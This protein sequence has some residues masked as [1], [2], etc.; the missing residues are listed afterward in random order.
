[1]R[2]RNFIFLLAFISSP[3]FGQEKYPGEIAPRPSVSLGRLALIYLSVD[4]TPEQR[5]KLND[6]Y[7]EFIFLVDSIGKATLEDVNGI[8]D[9]TIIDS[10]KSKPIPFFNPR[11][12]DGIH[13]EGIF[14]MNMMYPFY[15]Y[16]ESTYN[17]RRRFGSFQMEEMEYIEKSGTGFQYMMGAVGNTFSGSAAQYLHTG[18]GMKLDFLWKTRKK[19]SYGFSMTI[20]G[21]H[22]R[23]YYPLN[24]SRKLESTPATMIVAAS[25]AREAWSKGRNSITT[26][27]DLG[28]VM[29]NVSTREN[30]DDDEY[31]QL[32]GFSPGLTVNYLMP[33]G[34]ERFQNLH[35][36]MVIGHFINFHA[37]IRPL[38]M[39]FKPARGIMFEIGV[40][41]LLK[42]ENVKNYQVKE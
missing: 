30:P 7:L 1:M 22:V 36:P 9:P 39:S 4:F 3:L 23:E 37:G 14:F 5:L 2:F 25:F 31:I 13:K 12:V 17:G 21:N 41:Y 24:T 26:Q 11:Q 40:S 20:Y 28:Y 34:K 6:K 33:L 32:A 8:D 29:Q 35:F 16:Y 27:L 15:E 10:L 38:L 19:F 18:G 42:S